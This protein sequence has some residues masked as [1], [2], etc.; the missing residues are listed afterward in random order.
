MSDRDLKAERQQYERMMGR[1]T[2]AEREYTRKHFE[3]VKTQAPDGCDAGRKV[4]AAKDRDYMY[5][6]Y[7]S[8]Y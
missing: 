5:D 2:E 6:A 3:A 4:P 8:D 7:D 1:C